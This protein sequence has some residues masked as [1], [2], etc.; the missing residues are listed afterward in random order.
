MAENRAL[1]EAGSA[2]NSQYAR[3]KVYSQSRS[4]FD[5]ESADMLGRAQQKLD[6]EVIGPLRQGG[7]YPRFANFTPPKRRRRCEPD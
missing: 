2:E 5:R 1:Q 6:R 7:Y 4:Q 3:N